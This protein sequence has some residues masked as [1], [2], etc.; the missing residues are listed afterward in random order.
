MHKAEIPAH[1]PRPKTA[2]AEASLPLGTSHPADPARLSARIPHPAR[3]TEE[4]E[5]MRCAIPAWS[6]AWISQ[7]LEVAIKSACVMG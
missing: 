1:P 2:A 3:F 6:K 5:W 4:R 7:I